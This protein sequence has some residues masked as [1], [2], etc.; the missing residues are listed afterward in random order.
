MDEQW[1][2]YAVLHGLD[3]NAP[4][5]HGYA[6]PLGMQAARPVYWTCPYCNVTSQPIDEEKVNWVL[7]FVMFL[8]CLPLFWLPLV[9]FKKRERYCPACNTMIG[10]W[11]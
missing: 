6:Q 3:P 4:P 8:F 10:G 2:Q 5:A 9:A 1:R 11:G 7:F